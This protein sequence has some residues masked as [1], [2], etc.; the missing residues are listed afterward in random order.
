MV[1]GFVELKPD[2]KDLP[3]TS[4]T[5][6]LIKKSKVVIYTVNDTKRLLG[7]TEVCRR[8]ECILDKAIRKQH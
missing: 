3:Q 5:T 4:E 2:C 8:G 6:K 1:P 7:Q